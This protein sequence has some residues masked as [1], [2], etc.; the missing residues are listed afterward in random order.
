MDPRRGSFTLIVAFQ[1]QI[2]SEHYIGRPFALATL[3][4]LPLRAMVDMPGSD[5]VTMLPVLHRCTSLLR[6]QVNGVFR[7]ICGPLNFG[8]SLS[9][10]LSP[11]QSLGPPMLSL[12]ES[13]CTGGVRLDLGKI[14]GVKSAPCS[15]GRSPNAWRPITLFHSLSPPQG[16]P[17]APAYPEAHISWLT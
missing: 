4:L 5:A 2:L 3:A 7:D 9:T 16:K 15:L 10:Q 12:G 13:H 14:D 1:E 6:L 8:N 11:L 17:H